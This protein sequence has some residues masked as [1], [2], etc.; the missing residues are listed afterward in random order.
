[1]GDG[2]GGFPSHRL[3]ASLPRFGSPPPLLQNPGYATEHAE[4]IIFSNHAW[5]NKGVPQACYVAC[6]SF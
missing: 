6:V 3:V 5:V 1:M 4:V 2:G